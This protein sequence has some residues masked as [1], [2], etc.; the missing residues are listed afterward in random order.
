MNKKA[1]IS[2]AI[3]LTMACAVTFYIVF[4]RFFFMHWGATIHETERSY[5]GDS[6]VPQPNY[7]NILAVTV[8]K[9][10]SDVWPW[11]AQMGVNKG[12]FYSYTWLENIFGCNLRNADRIHLE[13][14]DAATGDYEPVCRSAEKSKMPGWTIWNVTPNKALVYKSAADSSWSMGFY[15]DSVD[16]NTCRLLTRMRYHSPRNFW[17]YITDKI[18]LEWAHCIMQKGSIN[19]IRRRAERNGD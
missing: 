10:A 9:P 2:K 3:L 12:G 8:H 5:P 19:G 13:W 7:V 4:L 17:E 1:K 16:A 11:V 18:W 15:I 14:Q 6:I